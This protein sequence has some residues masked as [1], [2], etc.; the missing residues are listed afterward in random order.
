MA[1]IV[2]KY[3]R[4]TENEIQKYFDVA[5]KE[6]TKQFMLYVSQNVPKAYQAYCRAKYLRKPYNVLKSGN[7]Q[8]PKY[9]KLKEMG[10][11]DYSSIFSEVAEDE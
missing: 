6:D 5:P 11:S 2:V 8:Q 9:K 10:V 7:E 4:S 1:E 3:V